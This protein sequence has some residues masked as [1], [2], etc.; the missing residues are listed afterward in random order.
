MTFRAQHVQATGLAHLF[1]FLLRGIANAG[2][3]LIPRLLVLFGG[4]HRVEPALTQVNVR[5]DV[6][7]TAEHDVRT[8]TSHVRR[9]G[10]R[11]Q[12][13]G[14]R[15]NLRLFLVVLRVQH[16]VPHT[17]RLQQVRQVL[18]ALNRGRTDQHRLPLLHA[19]FDV[20]GHGAELRFLRLVDQ[21]TLVDTLVGPVGRDLV[22][23]ELVDLVQLGRFGL[24]GTGHA[25]QFVVQTEVILQRNRRQGLV[26][27]LDLYAFFGLDG[28]VH[29]L[30]VAAA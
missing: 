15:N 12:A 26:F 14:L 18:G 21:V 9:D 27:G 17:L 20:V 7:V 25:S 24:R 1:R 16:T 8:T 3:L 29:A 19:L 30:I 23:V 22:H 5:D 13:T 4:L 6:R 10:D 2:D 11:A 28:L